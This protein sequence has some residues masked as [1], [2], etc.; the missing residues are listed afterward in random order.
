MPGLSTVPL[1]ASVGSAILETS[2]LATCSVL[3]PPLRIDA[4][5]P[6]PH[7][8]Q[9]IPQPRCPFLW[10]PGAFTN[11]DCPSELGASCLFGCLI[12]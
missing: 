3:T 11:Q 2:A 4:T 12:P 7:P 9:P 1:H 5:D 8:D 6:D 10:I